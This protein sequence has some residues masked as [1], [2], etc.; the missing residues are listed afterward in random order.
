VGAAFAAGTPYEVTVRPFLRENCAPCHNSKFASGNLNIEKLAAGDA[1]SSLK[2]RSQWE[3]MVRRMRAGE[4]PPKS[5]KRP[6]ETQVSAV[7]DWV[8]AEYARLD[9]EA[10]R[11]PGHVT[12][13]RLNRFEYNNTVRDLLGIDFRPADDFPADPYGYGFDNIGDALSISPVLTE[14]YL[15]AAEHLAVLAIPDEKR[16]ILPTVQRY[17][18]ERMGQQQQLHISVT[19]EFPVDGEYTLRSGWYQ[20]LKPGLKMDTQFL[21]DGKA[22]SN[23]ELKFFTEMDRSFYALHVR[24]GAGKHKVDALMEV[25]PLW[26]GAKPYLEYIEIKGPEKQFAPERKLLTGSDPGPVLEKLAT[27]AYRRPVGAAELS[28]LVVLMKNAQKRGDSYPQAMRLA[29]EAILIN[30]NFLFRIERDPAGGTAHQVSDFELASRLSYFLWSSMPDD[31]LLK[32]AREGTLH[33]PE[34]LQAQAARMM[35]DEKSRGFVRNF[36]GQWLQTRN[37]DVLKPDAKKFP[38]FGPE[39]REDMQTETEMFFEAVVKEDRSILDFIDGHF[40]YLNDRLAKHYGIDGVVGPEFRR[41]DLDGTQR[42]GVLTQASVLTVSSYPTRT[43]PVIRG[44]WILE[45]LLNTPPPPPPPDVPA[46]DEKTLG[47]SA[48]MRQQLEQHRA[49]P[50]CAG[51]HARMDPL[52]F[53]LENYDAIGRWR[54]KDGSF[55]VDASGTLPNGKSFA[56]AAELKTILKDDPSVFVKALT[57]KML[58]YALGRGLETYDRATVQEI[59]QGVGKSGYRFSALVQSVVASVPFQ[60]RRAAVESTQVT[61]K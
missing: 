6:A 17:L 44:K 8:E 24:I 31:E 38:E 56:G 12:A 10:A 43:S 13:H 30:P 9:R 48:S 19:A 15:K 50:V 1:A 27:K 11:D 37:L 28:Q 45:N 42:S 59:A 35:A 21:V 33:Q 32:V 25:D 49:N 14:K 29:L 18:A 26:T 3:S 2:E 20:I 41:V 55:A 40:T 58:T 34:V 61:S 57:E 53:G 5:A 7:A 16:P 46:L 23:E 54:T 51:C 4:M 52:G 39:L 22:V 36:G 60:Q 47:Q